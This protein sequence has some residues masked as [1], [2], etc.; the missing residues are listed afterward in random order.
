MSE[1][2]SIARFLGYLGVEGIAI[3]SLAFTYECLGQIL[4]CVFQGSYLRDLVMYLLNFFLKP[5]SNYI[6]DEGWG[7]PGGRLRLIC[8]PFRELG[9]WPL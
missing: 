4:Y 8:S 5:V 2:C 1:I 6:A 9:A 7:E 3:P